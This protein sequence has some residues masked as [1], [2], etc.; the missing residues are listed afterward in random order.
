MLLLSQPAPLATTLTAPVAER[1]WRLHYHRSVR[2]TV[3]WDRCESNA[4]CVAAAP[5]VF[6]VDDDDVLHVLQEEPGEELRTQVEAAVRACPMIAL[7][8]SD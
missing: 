2:V 7:S 3:D 5:D 4:Q 6:R 8:I 1:K